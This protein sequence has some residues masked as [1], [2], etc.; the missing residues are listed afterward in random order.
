MDGGCAV[1]LWQMPKGNVMFVLSSY[2]NECFVGIF[3]VN[4]KRA[5]NEPWE[6][7]TPGETMGMFHVTTTPMVLVLVITLARVINTEIVTCVRDTTLSYVSVLNFDHRQHTSCT[8]SLVYKPCLK[9][10]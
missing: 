10:F 4:K 3:N 1:R 9:S 6:N 7:R 5:K 2:D 8:K